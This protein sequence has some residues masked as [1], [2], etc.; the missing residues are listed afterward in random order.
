MNHW[1]Y[2]RIRK[3]CNEFIDKEE[4]L[5]AEML[6]NYG[7]LDYHRLSIF[8]ALKKITR[9]VPTTTRKRWHFHISLY[10]SQ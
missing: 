10:V 4:K 9:M 8:V 7:L 2:D 3:L 5:A 1:D 6:G